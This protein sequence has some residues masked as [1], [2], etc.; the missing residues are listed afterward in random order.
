MGFGFN[1]ARPST[2]TAWGMTYLCLIDLAKDVGARNAV[3]NVN[4]RKRIKQHKDDG[5]KET[6]ERRSKRHEQGGIAAPTSEPPV[7]VKGDPMNFQLLF[8]YQPLMFL[9]FM[10]PDSMVVVERP[11]FG[12]LEKLPPSFY[13]AKYGT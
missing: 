10:G 12:I 2:I 8:K 4:K 5:R 9:D 11:M 13:K 7:P 6:E 3:L 1:P